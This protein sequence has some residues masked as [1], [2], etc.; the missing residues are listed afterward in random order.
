MFGKLSLLLHS[1]TVRKA[2]GN[3][4]H[5]EVNYFNNL[6]NL[7]FLGSRN[8]GKKMFREWV[9][10]FVFPLHTHRMLHPNLIIHLFYITGYVGQ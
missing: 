10:G 2:Q 4:L 7:S 3:N 9:N 8:A 1:N 5:I 6:I